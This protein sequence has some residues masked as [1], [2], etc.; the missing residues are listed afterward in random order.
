MGAYS[1]CTG[2]LESMLRS[3]IENIL[4]DELPSVQSSRLGVYH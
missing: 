2:D 4:G 1:V 3:V